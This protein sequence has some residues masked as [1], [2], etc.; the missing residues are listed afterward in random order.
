MVDGWWG[1]FG[2]RRTS[3]C[4]R[5]DGATTETT[6]YAHDLNDRLLAKIDPSG[7]VL[8]YEYDAAGHRARFSITN[9]LDISY[10]YDLRNRL[11]E[12]NANGKATQFS[13][14]AAGYRTNAV[15]PNGTLATYA[16]D[17]AGQLLSLVHG[18]ANP[19]GEPLASF[20]YAYDLS[21]N[22]THM[23]T[24]E[25][26]NSYA[27][28]ARDWLMTATYPDGKSE[29]FAYD[30]VGNRTSLVQTVAGGPATTTDYAYGPVNRLLSSSSSETNEYTYD[31]AGRLVAQT[32]DP[33]GGGAGGQSRAYGYDFMSRM[34]SLTDTNGSVFGYAFDGAGNRIRQSLN[35]CLSTR[36]VYD[37][38]NAVLELNA[39]NEVAWAWVNGPG[40]DQPVERIGFING[41]ARARQV[42]HADGLGSIG[43]LTDESGSAIQT[44]AYEA[45]GSIRAQTGADLNRV[46]FTAREALGDSRSFYY[47]RNRVLDSNTGRFTSEDP[48][49]FIDGPNRYI[50]VGDNPINWI[51]PLGLTDEVDQAQNI[52]SD[53]EFIQTFN[54]QWADQLRKQY[55]GGYSGGASC[56]RFVSDS[57]GN[58][59][60]LKPGETFKSSPNGEYI[61]VYGADGKAT[62]TR[63][64]GPH[65]P[66]KHSDPRALQPHSHIPCMTNPDGTPWLPAQ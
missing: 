28:D 44:Y 23:I 34:T 19:P 26:T 59:I 17:D 58:T 45:F 64:D 39:S 40:V 20:S 32:V 16:Y 29:D 30:P 4:T 15:W 46:T 31:S 6:A 8:A 42:F 5:V 1:T 43:A 50:Y 54:P 12:I 61:Q 24:L 2:G 7:Y 49:K 38:P 52:Q 9:V 48:L 21:G 3:M 57:K 60:P 37:G 11:T 36:F 22:R 25:G 18:R 14:D 53:I 51:D 65:S 56:S 35:D 62:G 13:Y 63:L 47:Y 41:T 66:L 55:P 33:A 27:Y 10:A